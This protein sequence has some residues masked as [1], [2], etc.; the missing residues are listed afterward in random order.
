MAHCGEKCAIGTRCNAIQTVAMGNRFAA[1][2]GRKVS[3]FKSQLLFDSCCKT[4]SKFTKAICY[5]KIYHLRLENTSAG[6]LRLC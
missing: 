5:L 2:E 3:L 6:F 4:V 1:D